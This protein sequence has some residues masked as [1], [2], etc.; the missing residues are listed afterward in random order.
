MN[1]Q[2]AKDM[3]S[4]RLAYLR[5]H[6]VPYVRRHLDQRDLR[7]AM[8]LVAQYWADEAD[9][10]VHGELAWSRLPE[11]D[12]EAA[13]RSLD[14]WEEEAKDP[15]NLGPGLS[16]REVE[17]SSYLPWDDN[18][19]T[20]PLFAQ[21]CTED[22]DQEMTTSEA[23]S[24]CVLFQKLSCEACHGALHLVENTQNLGCKG[25]GAMY[26]GPAGRHLY[27]AD[28]LFFA[29]VGENQRPWLEGVPPV[30]YE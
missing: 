9:D 4:Q 18:G 23:Y 19:E 26:D 21:Y 24:P 8:L 28:G 3:S 20:I 11:P 29:I 30:D 12:L 6:I 7:S 16:Q 2:A 25:C 10:A 5:E 1:D 17:E 14:D 13:L 22:C 27:E 15:T